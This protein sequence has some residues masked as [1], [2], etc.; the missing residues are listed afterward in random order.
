MIISPLLNPI[1]NRL[2]IMTSLAK[3]MSWRRS[4][5]QH[6]FTVTIRFDYAVL[7]TSCSHWQQQEPLLTGTL[8]R[9]ALRRAVSSICNRS[10][11]L[12][13]RHRN[14]N[15]SMYAN[16]LSST[17]GPLFS[18]MAYFALS[19]IS[20]R[21]ANSLSIHLIRI[22]PACCVNCGCLMIERLAI[23]YLVDC[24]TRTQTWVE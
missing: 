7:R 24:I 2:R 12:I 15:H 23:L 22:W 11:L 1:A 16:A 5:D 10:V 20:L 8:H 21:P 17:C 6:R 18:S 3:A 13:S 9:V 4:I 19:Q 14:A